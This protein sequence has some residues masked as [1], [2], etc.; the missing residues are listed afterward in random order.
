MA[1]VINESNF[2]EIISMP[3]KLVVLDFW[4][5]WCGPCRTIAPLIDE[6]AAEYEDKAIIGKIDITDDSNTAI[7]EKYGI[8]N[9]PTVIFVKN[10]EIVNKHVGAATKN[11]FE[12]KIKA[13]L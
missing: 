5:E 7:V 6:L 1:L 3:D 4:A 8:R 13:H 2:N 12:E 9:I 10:G 11:I